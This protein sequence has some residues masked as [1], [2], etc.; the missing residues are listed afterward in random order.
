MLPTGVHYFNFLP[1]E[2]RNE[3][4]YEDSEIEIIELLQ[5]IRDPKDRSDD[6]PKG[7][8]T[9]NE[10]EPNDLLEAILD[11]PPQIPQVRLDLEA[12]WSRLNPPSAIQPVWIPPT[13]V[14]YETL[15][16][17]EL[18]VDQHRTV[19]NKPK[20]RNRP[21]KQARRRAKKYRLGKR[22]EPCN[23]TT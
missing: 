9:P 2:D 13:T 8:L 21:N 19:A 18:P 7:T 1:E 14:T 6:T 20:K 10:E 22:V 12:L 15:P 3:P 4:F 16:K 5:R 23:S 11:L 17:P